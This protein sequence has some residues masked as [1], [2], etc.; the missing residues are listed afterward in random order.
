MTLSFFWKTLKT[1]RLPSKKSESSKSV[2]LKINDKIC[3]DRLKVAEKFNTFFFQQLLHLWLK[4][5][6]IVLAR[7][8]KAL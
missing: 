8:E 3:F 5:F 1:M 4:N 2:G 7:L 6:P